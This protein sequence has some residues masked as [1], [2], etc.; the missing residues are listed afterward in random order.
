LKKKKVINLKDFN[1]IHVLKYFALRWLY[2]DIKKNN[3]IALNLNF[4]KFIK[5]IVKEG[6]EKENKRKQEVK[7]TLAV[8][9]GFSA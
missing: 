9:V 8:I 7:N 2:L 3:F 6:L 1:A 5:V 4:I